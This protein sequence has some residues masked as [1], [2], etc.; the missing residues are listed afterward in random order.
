MN[1][2]YIQ[3]NWHNQQAGDVLARISAWDSVAEEYVHDAS[4]HLEKDNFLIYLQSKI[5]LTDEMRIL[6]IGCG[7]G[8]Y[9][10]A[11]GAK[12][13]KVVGVD[14]SPKMIEVAKRSA[15][16]RGAHNVEFLESDWYTCPS[17]AFRGQYDLVFAHTT[18]AVADYATLLK[19]MEAST[20]YCLLCKPARRTDDVFDRVKDMAGL[21]ESQNDDSIAYAFGT[22]WGLGSN[23]QVSYQKTVWT[24]ERK[25][26]DAQTWYLGRIKGFCKIDKQTEVKIKEYLERISKDGVVTETIN[27]TLVNM[28]WEVSRG[29]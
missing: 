29:E 19:M 25:L 11:L 14:F 13:K 23:P 8:A 4:R 2:A 24:S 6:D 26:E 22:V 10:I 12:V 5:A 27:T 16:A 18:P 17:E 28:F 1:L 3:E 9:S 20:Q 21:T 7:G 15:A